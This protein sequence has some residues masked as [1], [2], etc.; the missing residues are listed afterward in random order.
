MTNSSQNTNERQYAP[1]EILDEILLSMI[2]GLG[3]LLTGRLLERFGTA[4]NILAASASDLSEV[5]GV[6]PK[7]SGQICSARTR[8]RPEEIIA[9]CEKNHIS[10]LIPSDRRYP[11]RLREIH[12][13]PTVLYCLGTL[14]PQDALAVAV[15]G[16]RGNSIYG[17]RQTSLLAGGLARAGFTIV[18]G[19]ARG[20][21]S[22]AHDAALTAGGRTVAV[23]GSGLLN[24]FPPEN[25]NLAKCIVEHGAILSEFHPLMEP[26]AGNFPRRNRIVSGLSLGVLVVESPRRSGSLITAR[27]AMEQNREVFAVPGPVDRENSRGCHQLI[28]DGATLVESAD[29]M[30]DAFGPLPLPVPRHDLSPGPVRHPLEMSLNAREKAILALVDSEPCSIDDVIAHSEI[31]AGPTLAVL[32]VLQMKRLV[33]R[34]E[35]NRVRRI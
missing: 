15:V 19:L 24:L 12:D 6:G 14:D 27:L 16:T 10:I 5:S 8:C 21:D 2:D 13:P 7:L 31:G 25:R 17:Q 26:L 22:I 30:I 9:L 33:Q 18:S 32:G 29:D 28:R 35:G 20:I 11:V 3:P 1:E 34:D 23:L 4:E